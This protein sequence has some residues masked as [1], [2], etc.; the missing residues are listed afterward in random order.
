MLN[1]VILNGVFLLFIEEEKT[2]D[3]VFSL[4]RLLLHHALQ[5]ESEGWRMF[6][7]SLAI[8][9]GQVRF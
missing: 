1:W 3:T 7:D 9:H 5:Q 4:M 2:S 6:V 8:L